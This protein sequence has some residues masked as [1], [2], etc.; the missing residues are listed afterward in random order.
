M[1][2]LYKIV[3]IA[4]A[5]MGL[6]G[7]KE[8]V[9]D[10]KFTDKG[11]DMTL[12]SFDDAAYMGGKINFTVDLKDDFPLSTLKVKLMFDE[13]VV[14]EKVIRT[15]EYGQYVDFIRVPLLAEI[16]NGTATLE[17]V[18]QN[19]GLGLTEKTVEVAVSRPDFDYLNLIV[20]GKTYKMN[21][22]GDYKYSINASF[23][24]DASAIIETPS[25]N[26]AGDVIK[27]GWDG[28][29]V[30]AD[31][32]TEIPFSAVKSGVYTISVDLLNLTASPFGKIEIQ[33]GKASP[34]QT[35][36]LL[37]GSV[38]KFNAVEDILNW[39]LDFDFFDVSADNVITFKAIDG[40]YRLSLDFA[41]KFI[42]VEA[43][44]DN[45][46]TAKLADDGSGAVW[47]IGGAFGKPII[48]PNWNTD[49]G[50]YC[51]SQQSPKV[52]R[53]T[54][55]AGSSIA[56][57]DFSVKVFHQKGWGGEVASYTS[58]NDETGLFKVTDSGNIEN[59]KGKQLVSGKAYAIEVDFSDG[60]SS[61]SLHVFETEVPVS[62]ID[63]FINGVQATKLSATVYAAI[64]DIAKDADLAI[65]GELKGLETWWLD[66]DYLRLEGFSLKFNAMSGKYKVVMHLDGKYAEFKR[67]KDSENEA[68][69]AEH[70][71]WMM[72]WGLASPIMKTG[73]FA[74][75]P[76][77]AF[78]MAEVRDMVFQL[79]GT[80]VDEKDE[81]TLGGRFRF[82]YISAKYFAQDGW[83]GEC[84]K[85]LGN[86]TTVKL[87][88]SATNL[89]KL[90][91]SYNIELKDD[92]KLELGAKYV[93]TIDLSK[94]AS[95][96]VETI[97]LVKK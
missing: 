77:S 92:V 93:L 57:K 73:Q 2:K 85:I 45:V 4:V 24:A 32:E 22:I 33:A 15:K 31:S 35:L 71:L 62:G 55:V 48:G 72:G 82:D 10:V 41:Q 59:I 25:V 79:T 64:L 28:S 8:D 34:V 76:G 60:K 90:T 51:L 11:P 7:C 88:P 38:L 47:M 52:Y 42:R 20:G 83:G 46:N 53:I 84:G 27:I 39:D 14:S 56:V 16:P 43:M 3:A 26:D 74:F 78:S 17:F 61:P 75:N 69:I 9:P 21:R 91:N 95:D 80:A 68:T 40:L 94:A 54:L 44:A 58:V 1:R 29:K 18:A 66:P 12:A 89:L 67:M 70:G 6:M 86:P 50:A 37:Q 65:T 63:I 87:G 30:S 19:T 97:E 36:S 13:T 96:A 23:P 49:E 5:F 81:T